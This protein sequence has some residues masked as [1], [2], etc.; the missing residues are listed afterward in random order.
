[1]LQVVLLLRDDPLG[2]LIVN[3]RN[4]D[5]NTGAPISAER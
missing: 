1:M 4:A 2:P 3:G 5:K